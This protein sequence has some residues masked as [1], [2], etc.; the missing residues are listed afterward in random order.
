MYLCRGADM[1]TRY[2]CIRAFPL[3]AAVVRHRD[4]SAVRLRARSGTFSRP[5]RVHHALSD[6]AAYTAGTVNGLGTLGAIFTCRFAG[7]A[8][9]S[10]R[11]VRHDLSARRNVV[12]APSQVD[13]H[14]SRGCLQLSTVRL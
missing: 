1:A 8:L 2:V 6:F 5:P 10:F 3:I 11:C 9:W 14:S 13:R 12:E 4:V 7:V